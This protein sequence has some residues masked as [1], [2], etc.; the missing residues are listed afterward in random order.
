[1]FVPTS[2]G[3]FG[4]KEILISSRTEWEP[5]KQRYQGAYLDIKKIHTKHLNKPSEPCTSEIQRPNTTACIA[6]F[7][8]AKL[9]CSV[10]IQGMRSSE[11]PP[12]Q[13]AE[14]F[15][16]FTSLSRELQYADASVIYNMTGCLSSCEKDKYDVIMTDKTEQAW[17]YKWSYWGLS[18]LTLYI[19][20]HESAYIEEEEYFIYDFDTFIADVGGYMGLLLGSS[21]I[22]L[23]DEVESLLLRFRKFN[24][25][26]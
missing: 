26:A 13:S 24:L 1:M 11:R 8:E 17:D 19:N 9:G 25:F 10:N 2:V 5:Y 3:T 6:E 21:I 22:S 15:V 20:M 7:I 4:S 16:E 23:M 14:Q 12:C 18:Y